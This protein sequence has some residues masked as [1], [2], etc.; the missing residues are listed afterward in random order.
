[1]ADTLL[2]P[3]Q[4]IRFRI[5]PPNDAA[6]TERVE[7]FAK[8]VWSRKVADAEYRFGGRWASEDEERVRSLVERVARE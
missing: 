2:S 7:V 4:T 5:D 8:V 3:G 6:P 1:M